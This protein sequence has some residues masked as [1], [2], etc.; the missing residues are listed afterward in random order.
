MAF[1]Y[2][3]IQLVVGQFCVPEHAVIRGK[4]IADGLTWGDTA[5]RFLVPKP[6]LGVSKR[7]LQKSFGRMFFNQRVAQWRNLGDTQ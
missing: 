7:D 3:S 5:L 2:F 1:N 6:T 4:V